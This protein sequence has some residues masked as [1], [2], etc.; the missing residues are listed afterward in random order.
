MVNLPVPRFALRRQQQPRQPAQPGPDGGR[1]TDRDQ[2]PQQPPPRQ[3]RPPT[4]GHLRRERRALVRAREER[5]RDLGGLLL[6]MYK[7]E[8]FREDLYLEQRAQI[9]SIEDRVRE[10]DEPLALATPPH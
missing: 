7:R 1:P 3:Q 5:I 9:I 8:H 10:L 2:Q 6:E 4:P